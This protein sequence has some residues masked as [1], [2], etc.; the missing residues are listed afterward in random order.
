VLRK[1]RY[2]LWYVAYQWARS[3]GGAALCLARGQ[4]RTA[5]YHFATFCGRVYGWLAPA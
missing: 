4:V 2:P 3:L 1:H 5:R